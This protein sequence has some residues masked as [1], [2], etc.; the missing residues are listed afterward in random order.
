MD[1]GI[2]E[3]SL[4]DNLIAYWSF[5]HCDAKDDSNHGLT[6]ILNGDP[7][8][9]DGKIGKAFYFDGTDDQITISDLNFSYDK[10]SISAWVLLES[11]VEGSPEI[12]GV[13]NGN[14]RIGFQL[15]IGGEDA[16]QS[17]MFD[18]PYEYTTRL[19]TENNLFKLGNWHLIT[20]VYD[21]ST[22]KI[23]YDTNLVAES[24]ASG[25]FDLQNA[26]IHIGAEVNQMSS[27]WHGYLDEIRLYK[28]AL[29]YDEIQQLYDTASL[30]DDRY[31]EGYENGLEAG[32]QLCINDP[33]ACGISI[34]GDY[35]AGYEAGFAAGQESCGEIPNIESSKC[36][37][38]D[39]FTNSLH[40]PCFSSG[41]SS[42][43]LD[44]KIINDNP[45]QL[46]LTNFGQN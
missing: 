43:W 10:L 33:A 17:I 14:G 37:N 45:V 13:I 16:E 32:K 34:A 29:T 2:T 20:G 3:A 26:T 24:H 36:A 41:T 18:A 22:I 21:G 23:Y 19:R 40:I 7:Q 46:E 9:V 4:D 35:Q 30:N 5:D 27:F 6:G 39:F 25:R 15:E 8:C 42:Y 44:L 12:I 31:Q 11:I 38:F 1:I 28:R